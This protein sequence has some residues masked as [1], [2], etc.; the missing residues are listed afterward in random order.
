MNESA[1]LAL[2]TSAICAW[3]CAAN[4]LSFAIQGAGLKRGLGQIGI[5]IGPDENVTP[6]LQIGH[7]LG[8]CLRDLRLGRS[9][10]QGRKHAAVFLDGLEERPCLPRK[11][12]GQLLDVPRAAGR[13]DDAGDIGLGLQHQLGVAGDAAGKL[14]GRANHVVKGSDSHATHAADRAGK[15]LG[16]HAQHVDVGIDGRLVPSSSVG[17]DGH[18][19]GFIAA[20]EGIDDL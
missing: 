3:R 18:L 4:A 1:W 13:V 8:R 17:V 12:V 15:G 9:R 7:P 14:V 6:C 5:H 20:A 10:F 16:G 11:L 2:R 19:L